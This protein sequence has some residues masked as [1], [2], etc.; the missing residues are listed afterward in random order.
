MLTLTGIDECV[1]SEE[2]LLCL[3]LVRVEAE[4]KNGSHS[5]EQVRQRLLVGP[6]V[7]AVQRHVQQVLVVSAHLREDVHVVV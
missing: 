1:I 6:A 2:A 5:D 4:H 7:A 3:D